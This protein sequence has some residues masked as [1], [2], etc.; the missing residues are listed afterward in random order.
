MHQEVVA[1]FRTSVGT[2]IKRDALPV[3]AVF[4]GSL[5]TGRLDE[6]AL[7]GLGRRGKEM[8]ATFPA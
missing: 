5:P 2:L 3:P 6:D 1:G 4:L 8:T 7:H